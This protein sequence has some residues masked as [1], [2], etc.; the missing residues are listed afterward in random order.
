MTTTSREPEHPMTDPVIAH[1][2]FGGRGI[3]RQRDSNAGE[4]VESW[5]EVAAGAI[6]AL[7]HLTGNGNPVP[8]PMVYEVLGEL[9][10]LGHRLPQALT[11]LA[12]G[13]DRSLDSFTV[14]DT[15][16]NPQASVIVAN[17]LLTQAAVLAQQLGEALTAAQ[18]AIA[19]QGYD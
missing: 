14:T 1:T 7:N 5:P 9:A 12:Q 4:D 13:L 18:Q 10:T 19:G 16:G 6:R 3:T 15:R 17:E 8:A 11:Q 2:V